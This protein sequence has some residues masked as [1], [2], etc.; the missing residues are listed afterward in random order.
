VH[1]LRVVA[2]TA[3]LLDVYRTALE[4]DFAAS[5]RR[6]SDAAGVPVELLREALATVALDVTIGALTLAEALDR[7]LRSRGSRPSASAI[8]DLVRTD[9]EALTAAS[10][11]YDDVVPFLSNPATS[12]ICSLDE[13]LP[14]LGG[15]SS[16]G[17]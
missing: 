15:P 7:A 14:S 16:I 17:V 8:A 5:E 13:L 1:R 6:L 12:A 11:V 9:G 3:V 4:V 2:T 10:T